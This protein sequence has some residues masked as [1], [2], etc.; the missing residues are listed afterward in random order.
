MLA[1]SDIPSDIIRR[2]PEGLQCFYQ[3]YLVLRRVLL[4]VSLSGEGL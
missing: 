1:K 3:F 4:L 2:V